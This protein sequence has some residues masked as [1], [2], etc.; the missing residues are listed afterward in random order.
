VSENWTK[1]A[2]GRSIDCAL[3]SKREL[4]EPFVHHF[5]LTAIHAVID[6]WFESPERQL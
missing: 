5:A 4:A 1:I 3:F 2:I 6:S